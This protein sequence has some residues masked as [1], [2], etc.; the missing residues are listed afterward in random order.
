MDFVERKNLLAISHI[1]SFPKFLLVGGTSALIYFFSM[2]VF[3]NIVA[4]HYLIAVSFSY[5]FSVI[6]HYFANC[7]FTFKAS[8]AISHSQI[9]RYLTMLLIN[10]CISIVI[11]HTVVEVYHLSPYLGIAVSIL[12]TMLPGYVMGKFWIFR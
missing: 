3:T 5:V 1:E 10:Y 9:A 4:P 8:T 2:W 7:H 6:F 11:V 12:C